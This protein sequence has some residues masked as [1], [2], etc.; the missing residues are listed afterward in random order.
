MSAAVTR[1]GLLKAGAVTGLAAAVPVGAAALRPAGLV[2]FDGR[3]PESLA[4][5]RSAGGRSIDLALEH[6]QR[7]ATLRAGLPAGRGIEGLTRW[8]DYIALRREFYRQGLRVTAENRSGAL[9]RWS[10]APRAL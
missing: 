8:S 10:M 1:R 4:F 9:I 3:V 5:A 2:V 7:F 6:G